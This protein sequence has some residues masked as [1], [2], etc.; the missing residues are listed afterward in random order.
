MSQ[1]TTIDEGLEAARTAA[2]TA[3][4]TH[5]EQSEEWREAWDVF[6]TI[7]NEQEDGRADAVTR[8]IETAGKEFSDVEIHTIRSEASCA[9][10][11]LDGLDGVGE[12]MK[13]E[14][15]EKHVRWLAAEP[16]RVKVLGAYHL[17][18]VVHDRPVVGG[19]LDRAIDDVLDV[20]TP[21][22]RAL[23]PGYAG[24]LFG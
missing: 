1:S 5:G 13:L 24:V 14:F 20:L 21:Y 12:R 9:V 6:N 8:G 16:L 7:H 22:V 17:E 11:E 3:E 15:L 18:N 2:N 4:D 23:Q 10:D 19:I